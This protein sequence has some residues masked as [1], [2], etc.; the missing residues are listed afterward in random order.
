MSSH[1]SPI[2]VQ[3]LI[4]GRQLDFYL[5]C[6]KSLA[7]QC[8]DD[9]ELL[10]HSDG[11]LDEETK[12]TI[13]SLFDNQKI[14]FSEFSVSEQKTLDELQGRANCQRIRKESLW[15]MEF[16]DPLF[17][18]PDHSISFYVDADILFV[19]PFQGLFDARNV[20]G[21][22]VF[23]RDTQWDAYSLRPWHLLGLGRRPSIV[24]GITTALV[25]WARRLQQCPL[26]CG[27]SVLR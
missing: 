24:Q 12:V 21:G 9:L 8:Q 20:Q 17:A 27:G 4:G 16:F 23:L 19:R 5:R 26:R 3:S 22:A 10:L 2:L 25:C 13:S 18:R 14:R 15:G 11:S 6:L 7:D 1:S